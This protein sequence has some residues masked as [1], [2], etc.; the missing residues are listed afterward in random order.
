MKFMEKNFKSEVK[1][2]Q[3]ANELAVQLDRFGELYSTSPKCAVM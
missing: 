3:R 2:K 1:E